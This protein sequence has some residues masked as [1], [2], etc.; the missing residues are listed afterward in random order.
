MGWGPLYEPHRH[1]GGA[2][3]G[4]RLSLPAGEYGV[5]IGGERVPSG[6]P[7][8]ALEIRATEGPSHVLLTES[9]TGLA[10]AFSRPARG[11][12]TLALLGGG[13]FILK[14]IRL[15]RAT[16]SAPSGPTQ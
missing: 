8:P 16:F 7:L 12:V 13:P 6:L 10:G 15:T 9:G 3:I 11:P 5:E 2:A 4:S 1:P 14:E